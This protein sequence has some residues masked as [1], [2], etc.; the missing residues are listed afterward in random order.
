MSTI[1][2][3]VSCG[4]QTLL[5]NAGR[6][7]L[8]RPCPLHYRSTNGHSLQTVM[9]ASV[10]NKGSNYIGRALSKYEELNK[11]KPKYITYLLPK[12]HEFLFCALKKL[13]HVAY[14]IWASI[15]QTTTKKISFSSLTAL[16]PE[17]L[18][19]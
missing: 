13:K 14:A 16:L 11:L 2:T 7:P 9:P 15:L 18:G 8:I 1:Y 10:T 17:L 4:F 19:F 5:T 12:I 3:E 6:V